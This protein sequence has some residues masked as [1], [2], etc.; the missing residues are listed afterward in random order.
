MTYYGYISIICFTA[1]LFL[2]WLC[3]W[4]IFKYEPYPVRSI[5]YYTKIG[6]GVKEFIQDLFVGYILPLILILC[7]LFGF[8]FYTKDEDIRYKEIK[9]AISLGYTLY[10]NGIEADASHITLE[11]YNLDVITI[12]DEI[13]E[14]HIAGNK[15]HRA[16]Y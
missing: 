7:G 9:D 1:I 5:S 11:D 8:L 14:V 3:I 4:F 10:I 2:F 6:D 16:D 15:A 13:K 12:E